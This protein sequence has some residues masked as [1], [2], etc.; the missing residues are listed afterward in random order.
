MTITLNL[1]P[2]DERG[3]LAQA[4]LRCLSLQDY[5]EQIVMRQARLAETAAGAP[6]HGSLHEF[7]MN[8]PLRGAGL[9]LERTEDYPRCCE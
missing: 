4:R 9:D 1:E 3:P 2:E 5:A 6:P 7:F 8:S